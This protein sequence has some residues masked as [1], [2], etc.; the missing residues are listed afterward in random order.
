M[1]GLAAAELCWRPAL[2]RAPAQG[3]PRTSTHHPAQVASGSAVCHDATSLLAVKFPYALGAAPASCNS[4]FV[5]NALTTLLANAAM[6]EAALNAALGLP[7]AFALS[8]TNTL[9]GSLAGNADAKRAYKAGIQVTQLT[10]AAAKY[11]TNS[12]A[13]LGSA[14]SY[15]V[16]ALAA[17]LDEASQPITGRRLLQT[18]SLL[19]QLLG[20][21]QAQHPPKNLNPRPHA[22]TR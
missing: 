12:S 3:R 15:V 16:S 1:R 9:A 13:H 20:R 5:I 4:T 10:L 8:T 17:R 22:S 11:V 19:G 7:A 18:P 21:G 14:R 2:P 6:P